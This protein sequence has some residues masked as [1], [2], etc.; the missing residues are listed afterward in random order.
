MGQSTHRN[1]GRSDGKQ[2]PGNCKT[3]V[4]AAVATHDAQP[5]GRRAPRGVPED[6]DFTSAK[7]AVGTPEGEGSLMLDAAS[8]NRWC[9]ACALPVAS[10]WQIVRHLTRCRLSVN[11]VPRLSRL[12]DALEVSPRTAHS[13]LVL[14]LHARH[15]RMGVHTTA[16]MN[17]STRRAT[18]PH[19]R[20]VARE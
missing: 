13:L 2:C 9:V 8:S 17:G 15:I 12:V 16:T 4:G 1:C 3:D 20:R 14:L 7:K 5:T 18:L 19:P 10:L 6:G 11:C